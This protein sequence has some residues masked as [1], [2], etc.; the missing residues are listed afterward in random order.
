MDAAL[1]SRFNAD[2]TP[3]RYRALLQTINETERWPADFRIAET[4]IFLT[5][6]FKR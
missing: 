2:F 4:P 5:R 6:E 1:R 3:E